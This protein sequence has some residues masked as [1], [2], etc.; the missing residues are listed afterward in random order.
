MAGK[1]RTPEEYSID[2]ASQEMLIRAEELGLKTAFSRAD[3]MKACPI[4]ADNLCCKICSMGPC[5]IVKEGQTGICGA[6]A[7]TIQARNFIRMVA[8]GA[9]AHSD[10]GRDMAFTLKEVANGET[11]GYILRDVAKL[12]DIASKY[13]IPIEGRSPEEIAND[14]ADL[15]IAQFGQQHG[16]VAT[17]SRAPKNRLKVWKDLGMMPRGVDREIVECLHRTHIGDDQDAEHIL[18]HA[19]RTAIG[20]G[21]GGS[22]I[23]TDVSDI[24]FGSP[25]PIL[26]EVNLGV[27]KDDQVNVVVHGHEPTL[28]NMV[29][30]ASQTPEILEYAKKAG[31]KGVNITGICCTA[32]EVLMRQGIPAAGNF[33]QQELAIMTGAV[34]AMVVDVQCIMQAL[35][36]LAENFHTEVITTSKKVKIK[37]ATHIEFDEK[38]ALDIAKE[39]LRKA[40]D[41]YK[42]RGAVKIPDH[43]SPVVPGFSHEYI[44]YA[45][46]GSY[47]S[48]FRPLNDG[49]IS[50]RIRGLVGIVG[51]NNPREQHDYLH[52]KIA[53]EL[54][55]NDVL[56][57]ETGC[58]SIASAKAGLL[59]GEAGLDQVGPGLREICEATGMP[60][61]LHMGSCVDNSRILTVLAQVVEE[62]G[63]G[64]DISEIPVVGLAPE[65]MSEKAISIATYVVASGVYTIMSGTAP[66]ASNPR[67]PDSMIVTE[68]L[69]AG[70]EK[71]VGAKLEFIN[72]VDTIVSKTLEHIDKKRAELGLPA[73]DPEAFGKSGDARMLEIE[74]LPVVDRR[75]AIYG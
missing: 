46:G 1:K 72:D 26:G 47:R 2:P 56:L 43:K 55:K 11:Q 73:Y 52:V 50:G 71:K 37:G 24:L 14:L 59:V 61:V 68:L 58:S 40:I 10:H 20:D 18:D 49:V 30:A 21:W 45:L 69:S 34:E 65:W 25:A 28:S 66:V 6:T 9:A 67:V 17:V 53:E 54:L 35:V 32:N 60:P 63:L 22:L 62:G 36:G 27:L 64:E 70:W 19:L 5:R 13:E 75:E 51:C 57:V 39:I 31:A 7:D 3:E 33:L 48:S 15:Y 8:G 16:T 44:N 23:A 29:V 41:N 4:G 12:R 42:N 74:S 38:K